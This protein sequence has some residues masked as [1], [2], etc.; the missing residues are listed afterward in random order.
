MSNL[1]KLEQ[2]AQQTFNF[3]GTSLT[4][5]IN[6]ENEIF[7]IGKEVATVLGYNDTDQAIRKHCKRPVEMAGLMKS[8]QKCIVIPESDLYRLVMKSKL[9]SAEK[10]E[11][12]VCED[13]LP[14]IRQTGGYGIQRITRKEALQQLLA[15]IEKNEEQEQII[16]ELTPLA[17]TAR[18]L[19]EEDDEYSIDNLA[20][21][22]ALV[23]KNGRKVGRNR[24]F[25]I[26]R[27]KRLLLQNTEHNKPYIMYINI[28][29]F[30]SKLIKQ[31]AKN[32]IFITK[33]TPKGIH[34]L[35][36]SF[37]GWGYTSTNTKN[38]LTVI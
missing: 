9:P 14:S 16:E 22:L 15:Q 2:I 10:F 30:T 27:E 13:V 11:K 20:R 29:W 6:K 4:T 36:K 32:H 12:W 8:G 35:R 38:Y 17:D 37:K 25:R 7:F 33:V 31:K 5:I 3:N 19:I 34:E 26:L 24:M 23:D 1:V 28:G 21:L 18:E